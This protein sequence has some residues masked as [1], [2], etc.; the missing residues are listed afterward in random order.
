MNEEK[1]H[2]VI[3]IINEVANRHALYPSHVFKVMEE[4]GCITDYLVPF[5]DV[6]HTMSS[7]SVVD[8]VEEYVR[9]RGA[10]L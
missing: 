10:A 8:D 4:T 1:A 5:Y 2:F 3:Y 9:T 6:L 7:S